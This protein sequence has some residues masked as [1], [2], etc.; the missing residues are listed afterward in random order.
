M[1]L[2]AKSLYMTAKIILRLDTWCI[3]L[4]TAHT[5]A[6]YTTHE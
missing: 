2:E 6:P 5:Q 1:V 3:I 4:N